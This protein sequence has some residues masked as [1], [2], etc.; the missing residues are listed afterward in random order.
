MNKKELRA[1]YLK[2]RG[3]LNSKDLQD[4]EAEILGYIQNHQKKFEGKRIHIFLPIESKLEL[5]TYPIIESLQKLNAEIYIPRSNFTDYSMEAISYNSGTIIKKNKYEIP[6]P[7]N[8]NI[9]DPN[10]IDI[11]FIPM[12]IFDKKGYRV[13]YGK[14]FYDRY[15]ERSHS[16][17]LK[18]GL[19]I[20]EPVE[21]IP[22]THYKDM[23][24]DLCI[25]KNRSY[26]FTK[27]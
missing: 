24:L 12:I 25:S 4:F 10:S 6:E 9:L 8:G 14:G 3:E 27:R 21:E 16:N 26:H 5:N 2:K 19:C 13:G 17:I 20:F 23:P 7:I 11:I 1:Y 22:D 15:L 18:I